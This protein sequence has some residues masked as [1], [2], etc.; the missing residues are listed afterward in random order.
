MVIVRIWEGL[1]NQMFQYAYAKALNLKGIDVRLD[2]ANA[3]DDVF[4]I[5][6]N[7]H[8]AMR[9]IC[10]QK[11]KISLPIIDVCTYGKYDYIQQNTI[12]KKII[13]WLAKHSLWKYKFV[14]EFGKFHFNRRLDNKDN[15]YIKGYFQDEKYFKHIRSTL[16]K[17]FVPPEKIKISRELKNALND[18]ESVSLHIRRGDYVKLKLSLNR[19]YYMK[20]IEYIKKIYN[21]P[22]FVVFSDDLKWVRENI[23]TNS[24]VVYAN[25][26]G[27]LKDYEELFIMS[28]CKSNIISNSTFSWWAAW[29]NT[30]EKKIVIAPKKWMKPQENI[31]PNDWIVIE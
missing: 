9:D 21:N 16:L 6:K 10:I 3:F 25:E 28:R 8:D 14:E 20:A 18:N 19:L 13:F 26:D 5:W 4:L 24:R 7:K 11:F 17:E 30:Y 29:L 12:C 1:G 31:I 15:Y 27:K 23:D 22:I 2:L